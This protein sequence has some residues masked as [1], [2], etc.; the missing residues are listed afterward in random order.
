MTPVRGHDQVRPELVLPAVRPAE[1]HTLDPAP[2]ADQSG[3]GVAHEQ[4]EPWFRRR[5]AS[6]QV[7][8]VPLRHHCHVV[9]RRWEGVKVTHG[10]RR[11]AGNG[12]NDVLQAA[13][14][15]LA[16][17][18]AQPELVNQP[19]RRGVHRVAAEVPQ[20]VGVFFQ[21][22]HPYPRPGQQQ[23]EHHASRAAAHHHATGLLHAATLRRSGPWREGWF[24]RKPAAQQL[25]AIDRAG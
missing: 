25:S 9:V 21:Y 19:D 3:G 18:P 20:K 13:L 15:Q 11:A 1:A 7:Q 14:R 24:A 16:E 8:E 17:L 2:V 5:R 4:R 6:Q 23:P 22:R 10:D 12:K